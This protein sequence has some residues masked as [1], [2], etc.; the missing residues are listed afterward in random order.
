MDRPFSSALDM[1]VDLS[2]DWTESEVVYLADYEGERLLEEDD[3]EF[4][5]EADGVEKYAA[6]F[7]NAVTI[8]RLKV[9]GVRRTEDNETTQGGTP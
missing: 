7:G 6:I 3:I 1:R 4:V 8:P 5:G 9:L 2:D